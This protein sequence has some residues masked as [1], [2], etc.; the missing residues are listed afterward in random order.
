MTLNGR[1]LL[2]CTPLLA[3]IVVIPN[4]LLLFR[5]DRN[6]RDALL[7]AS[8]NRDVDVPKLR[9]AIRVIRPS[10]VLRLRCKL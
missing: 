5:I 8:F 6:D 4:E 3:G 2:G 1:G 9:I 10:S 7:Q